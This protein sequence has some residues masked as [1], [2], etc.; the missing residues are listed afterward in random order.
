MAK[1]ISPKAY[2]DLIRHQFSDA[3]D[4][5]RAEG[6]MRYMR[7]RFAYFGLRAPEWVVMLKSI[8]KEHG[9]Y[10]G[11]DLKTFAKLCFE[12]ECREMFYAGLQ[13]ME[14]Q[15]R[16]QPESF[17]DFLEKAVIKG[18]WW[19]TVDWINKLIGIH[20]KRYPDIQYQYSRKWI[21][22]DSI[23]LQRVAIL[24]QLLYRKETDTTLLSEMILYRKDSS[25][26]FVQKGAGWVLREYSKT[27]PEWVKKFIRSNPDLPKLTVREGLKWLRKNF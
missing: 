3:G 4:P 20:F 5:V 10:D 17:I 12:E 6:Q 24:H 16:K 22:S 13:M 27:N 7:H 15:I 14:K 19:D 2:V 1:R 23:W 11:K 18:A 9:M 26:F 21:A 25:E 8:F